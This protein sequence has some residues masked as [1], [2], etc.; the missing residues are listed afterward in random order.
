[1][2]WRRR[3]SVTRP[4]SSPPYAGSLIA[5]YAQTGDCRQTL[6]HLAEYVRE[7]GIDPDALA[8]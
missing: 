8:S 7:R 4:R 2:G 6:A 5:A 1:M 3:H